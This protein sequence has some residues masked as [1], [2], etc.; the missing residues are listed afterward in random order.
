MSVPPPPRLDK[1][2]WAV[3]LFKTR[4]LASDACRAN[5]VKLDGRPLKPGYHPKPGD[6]LNVRCGGLTRDIQVVELIDKR[7]SA[8]IA[9]TC[10]TDLTDPA[11]LERQKADLRGNTESRPRGS[12]RPGKKERRL[13]ER[14]F[15]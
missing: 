2:L 8:S 12:G 15:G 9:V 4:S 10:Y 3:R 5:Q 7:V 13:L 1:W 6:R 14:F 11:E